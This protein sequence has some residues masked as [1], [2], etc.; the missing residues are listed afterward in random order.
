M[1][2]NTQNAQSTIT[3]RPKIANLEKNVSHSG[4]QSP[5][6]VFTLGT[7][8]AESEVCK[9]G[10]FTPVRD[11]TIT[12][13]KIES[14]HLLF[15]D[16]FHDRS[17]LQ[18]KPIGST[19]INLDEF[20]TTGQTAG[21]FDLYHEDEYRGNINLEIASDEVQPIPASSIE[22]NTEVNN[23]A[24]E[25]QTPPQ[26]QPKLIQTQ[27]VLLQPQNVLLAQPMLQTQTVLLAQPCQ[28]AIYDQLAMNQNFTNQVPVQLQFANPPFMEINLGNQGGGGGVGGNNQCVINLN[29]ANQSTS[30]GSDVATSTSQPLVETNPSNQ[31]E[32]NKQCVINVN[33]A[34]Q[35]M[36][37]FNDQV[38]V[39]TGAL[40]SNE[41][42]Y[43]F[44]PQNTYTTQQIP[45]YQL[46][47]MMQEVF[48]TQQG[49]MMQQVSMMQQVP[50]QQQAP[51]Q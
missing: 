42:A 44:Q 43:N 10:G 46:V 30:N 40:L 33:M 20:L 23:Q 11:D 6:I 5:Y 51:M 39:N 49:P 15:V 45:I 48:M 29:M 14:D 37:N 4:P 9:K 25:Q 1:A 22:S 32:V 36:P 18:D 38:A 13:P 50:V 12:L 27:P 21:L 3:L 2:Q 26:E 17:M 47:P 28:S 34:N 8:R 7:A 24:Q 35:P 19:K 16:I 41:G 31:G